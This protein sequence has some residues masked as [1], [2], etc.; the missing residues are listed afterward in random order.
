MPEVPLGMLALG[1]R[2]PLLFQE[3]QGTELVNFL[4][5]AVERSLRFWLEWSA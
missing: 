2:D 5:R 1:S 3:L 4:A